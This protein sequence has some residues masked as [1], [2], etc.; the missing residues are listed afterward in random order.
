MKIKHT[1]FIGSM[2]ERPDTRPSTKILNVLG[3]S[4][5]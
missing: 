1:L 2:H 5:A 3:V 4:G